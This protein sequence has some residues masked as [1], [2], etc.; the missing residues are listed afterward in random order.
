MA[1]GI[2][3]RVRQLRTSLGHSLAE[4][5]NLSGVSISMLSHIERGKAT[6]SL[7]TLSSIGRAL[8]VEM[9]EILAADP[10]PD[11][12]PLG[13]FVIRSDQRKRV[14]FPNIGIY[15]E[16]LS[17]GSSAELEVLM[18]VLSPGGGSGPKPWS[19]N[20]EKAG[21]VLEGTFELSIGGSTTTLNP[22]DSFQFD[23][24]IPHTFLNPG[25]T[26][27]RIIWIIRSH[28]IA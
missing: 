23:G 24:R 22:G 14:D 16:I 21:V 12:S 4:V 6:P 20:S 5:S 11:A 17:V 19:R 18:L 26:E 28:D 13:D 2:G 25:K 7:T 27:A 15:K 8:G 3:T 10:V 1:S 9:N